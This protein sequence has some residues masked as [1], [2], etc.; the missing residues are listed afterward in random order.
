[1]PVF[2]SGVP[3]YEI[4][5]PSTLG[6]KGKPTESLPE[7][8]RRLFCLIEDERHLTAL[9]LYEDIQR[10]IES[11]EEH[12]ASELKS[13]R[14]KSKGFGGFGLKHHHKKEDAAAKEKKAKEMK[15][16]QEVLD[17]KHKEIDKL[18]VRYP[19]RATS[20]RVEYNRCRF[21]RVFAYSV[22]AV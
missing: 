13:K 9:K 2:V 15:D 20:S 14:K 11:W 7:D 8:V 16:A 5:P 22:D 12:Q 18:Q 1:M 17:S 6:D 3:R 10:R 4:K 19:F 21:G